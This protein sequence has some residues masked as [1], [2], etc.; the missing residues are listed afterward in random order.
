MGL[1]CSSSNH[2][3]HNSK[4]NEIKLPIM[5]AQNFINIIGQL[6]L[7]DD[8]P[9]DLRYNLNQLIILRSKLAHCIVRLQKRYSHYHLT[10]LENELT[11]VIHF[12]DIVVQ[13]VQ[14]EVYFPLVYAFLVEQLEIHKQNLKQQ[15]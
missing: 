15:I 4:I 11:R 14:L 9:D 10:E 2:K 12:V 3:P 5:I 6:E 8:I 1:A 13:D 7:S